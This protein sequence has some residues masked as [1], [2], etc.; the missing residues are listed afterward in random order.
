MS[1]LLGKKRNSQSDSNSYDDT[2]VCYLCGL[3]N[4]VTIITCLNDFFEYLK[5]EGLYSL[6]VKE[7]E[8]FFS[9]YRMHRGYMICKKCI[10]DILMKESTEAKKELIKVLELSKKDNKIVIDLNSQGVRVE[11]TDKK[12]RFCIENKKNVTQIQNVLKEEEIKK[13][14]EKINMFIMDLDYQIENLKYINFLQKNS[15]PLIYSYLWLYKDL[16][17]QQKYRNEIYRTYL[18]N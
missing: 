1:I 13:R 16:V 15:V 18:D 17:N 5:K 4:N 11:K 9:S 2:K 10:C 3:I 7:M 8:L 12:I 6:K 14:K